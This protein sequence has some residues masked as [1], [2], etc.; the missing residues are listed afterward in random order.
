M[1]MMVMAA[2]IVA[3]AL[4]VYLQRN[5]MLKEQASDVRT[6]SLSPFLTV[7]VND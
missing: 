6:L 5:R 1:I 2:A 4:R 7:A 3:Y